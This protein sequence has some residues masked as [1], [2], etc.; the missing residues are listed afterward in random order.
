MC[1]SDLFYY[2]T[3]IVGGSRYYSSRTSEQRPLL[4]RSRNMD[5]MS[6]YEYGSNSID[7][8]EFAALVRAAEQAIDHGVYPERIYQGSSGSYFVKNKDGVCYFC[9]SHSALQEICFILLHNR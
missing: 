2:S 7:E 1:S 5:S 8:P 3:A 6:D 4:G 9:I